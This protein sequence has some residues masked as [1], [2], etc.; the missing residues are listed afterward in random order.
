MKTFQGRKPGDWLLKIKR[1]DGSDSIIWHYESQ[2]DAQAE[3]DRL[4]AEIQSDI[5][6]VE[7]FDIERLKQAW[8]RHGR[9]N[10]WA[11]RISPDPG[12]DG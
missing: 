9:R 10:A 5:H 1:Y 8:P 3:A 2:D 6:Y 4:N 11:S 12:S 7:A